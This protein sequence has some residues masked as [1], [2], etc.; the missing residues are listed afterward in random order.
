MTVY[1][2]VF[3]PIFGAGCLIA[4]IASFFAARKSG[5]LLP[6]V[7]LALGTVAFWAGLF[8][9]SDFGYRVWQS[10]PDPPDEAFSDSAPAGALLFGWFPGGVFCVLVF[11]FFRLAGALDSVCP[12][13]FVEM[14]QS[15]SNANGLWL[16]LET[17]ELFHKW[18]EVELV[19][20]VIEA[21]PRE[22]LR[23]TR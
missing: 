6:C 8:I 2:H 22:V 15:W 12:D 1:D 7:L 20:R 10:M 9:G 4:A 3:F 21:A 18:F 11:G 16:P 5:C 13:I 19:K 14:S 17:L 23:E